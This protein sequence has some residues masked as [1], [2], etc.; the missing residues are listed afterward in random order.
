MMVNNT[1]LS[2]I[3]GA[4]IGA[5]FSLLFVIILIIYSCKRCQSSSVNQ[6]DSLHSIIVQK[7]SRSMSFISDDFHNNMT[8]LA[9]PRRLAILELQQQEEEI[10]SYENPAFDLNE[11][12]MRF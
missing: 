3:I 10:S 4:I 5:S 8:L 1:N 6:D 7:S 2:I 11:R 9:S 12:T